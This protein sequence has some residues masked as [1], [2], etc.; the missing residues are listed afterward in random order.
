MSDAAGTHDDPVDYQL[1]MLVDV[2][3]Y[4]FERAIR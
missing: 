1:A 4:A 2:L 3:G